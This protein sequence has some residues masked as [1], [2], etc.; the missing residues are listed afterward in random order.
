M[1]LVLEPGEERR[2][3]EAVLLWQEKRARGDALSPAE[4]QCLTTLEAVA[5]AEASARHAF[6]T[7]YA[8]LIAGGTA[9]SADPSVLPPEV[10]QSVSQWMEARRAWEEL[11]PTA[12]ALLRRQ[13]S[14]RRGPRLPART[15]A[16]FR[17]PTSLT[18]RDALSALFA[19]HRWETDA[20]GTA[21][22]AQL[23]GAQMRVEFDDVLGFG[24]E[25]AIQQI[26]RYGASVAQTFLSMATLWLEQN[27]GKPYETYLSAYASDLLRFQGRKATPRGGY[28][29][30]DLIAKGRDVYFLSRISIPRPEVGSAGRRSV[31]G[32]SLS[33]LLSLESLEAVTL[34]EDSGTAHSIVRFRYHLSKE[35]YDWLGGDNPQYAMVSSKLLSYH[36]MRQKYQILLGFCLAYVDRMHQDSPEPR[37][38]S[39]PALLTLADLSIPE[40]RP[41]AFLTMIEDALA[42]LARDG[43]I[44]AVRLQKPPDWTALLDARRTREV[45]ES[46]QVVFPPLPAPAPL[47]L[48]P[49]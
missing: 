8:G 46:S 13:A 23:T 42:D 45:L 16:T 5:A 21:L 34:T 9:E 26:A 28:H 7:F 30:D 10:A 3:E 35:V 18:A 29:R 15:P 14:I 4:R 32:L 6:Q 2:L 12:R 24:P 1:T 39:L 27:A 48:P 22:V 49:A 20:A 11:L 40:R 47:A 19:P 36:P 43:V 41:A 37:R 17:L 38:L 25:R 31:A 44:P 33:R